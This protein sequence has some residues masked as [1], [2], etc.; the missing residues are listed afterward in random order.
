MQRC[1]RGRIASLVMTMHGED[2][3]P[4]VTNSG[5]HQHWR[6]Y[7]IKVLNVVSQYDDCE[8]ALVRQHDV[9]TSLGDLPSADDVVAAL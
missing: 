6:Y 9:I 3:V 7:F 8:L 4:C 2:S 5:Q 1:K